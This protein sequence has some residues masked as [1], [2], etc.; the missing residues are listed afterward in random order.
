MYMSKIK[1]GF[2]KFKKR[3]D[4]MELAYDEM[5]G[6]FL[7][8]DSTQKVIKISDPK[9]LKKILE[10]FVPA[11]IA[12]NAKYPLETVYEAGVHIDTGALI[13]SNKGATLYCIS[14]RTRTPYIAQHIGMAIYMP[15]L[16]LEFVNVGLSGDVYNNKV[17]MRGESACAPSFLYGSQRCN[18]N[19][20]WNEL[21]ELAATYN[22]I[23][24]P[25]ITDGREFEKW[26]QKPL[27]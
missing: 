3:V 12:S 10:V 14:P 4:A 20:Q 17:V 27:T 6:G 1:K 2:E 7:S 16:G 9:K 23:V 25:D 26:V 15:S 24:P 8:T 21:Q 18:C 5:V 22:R 19:H 11:L 13:I